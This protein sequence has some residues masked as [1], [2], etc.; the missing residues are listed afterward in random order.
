MGRVKGKALKLYAEVVAKH[1][2]DTALLT[3]GIDFTVEAP[4]AW[5]PWDDFCT[6]SA[7]LEEMLGGPEGLRAIGDGMMEA[8]S[9]QRDSRILQGLASPQQLLW[10]S[11]RWGGPSL[12]PD[13]PSE[14]EKL[15]GQRCR[16]RITIPPEL[17]P[18]PQLFLIN[19]GFFATA[20]RL[21]GLRDAL[22]EMELEPRCGI[23]HITLPPSLTL[24]ARIRRAVSVLFSVQAVVEELGDQNA[25]IQQRF[26]DLSAARD[27]AQAARAEAEK[28]LA[29][30]TA[31]MDTLSHELRT[32]LNGILG[33]SELLEETGLSA[34]QEELLGRLRQSGQ[35]LQCMV[36]EMLDY[37][38]LERGDA[39]VLRGPIAL[40]PMLKE[41]C[42]V[43]TARARQKG[44]AFRSCCPDDATALQVQGDAARVRQVLMHLLDNALKFTTTGEVVLR[45]RG[46]GAGLHVEV[47]DTGMG[48]SVAQQETVFGAFTQAD[49]SMSRR[50]GGLGLGLPLARRLVEQMGG[51]MGLEPDRPLGSCFWFTL[52][53][54]EPAPPIC[55]GRVLLAEDNLLNQLMLRQHLD[56]L[57]LEVEVVEDGAAALVACARAAPDIVLMDCQM[58]GLDGLEA[59]AALRARG[60]TRPI[61]AVTANASPGDRERCLDAGM[62]D[63]LTKPVSRA[64]LAATIGHWLSVSASSSAGASGRG[65]PPGPRRAG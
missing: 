26:A 6:I 20:P 40:A 19:A 50:H 23:F 65:A 59:T 14:F 15:P 56:A 22:V 57:G 63:Y 61:V 58:P 60:F 29:V 35:A 13:L 42:A 55:G 34:E 41:L 7:R 25:L 2:L 9:F 4:P 43:Y 30:R 45:V 36:D 51:E 18:C 5:V 16:I 17:R 52:L 54:A 48:I 12:F 38:D 3:E 49:G 10:A 37:A 1:G 53:R 24:W 64:Q 46:T 44:V 62:D 47:C 31:F 32:P 33:F 27:A 11:V 39:P 8:A 28:A 21:L